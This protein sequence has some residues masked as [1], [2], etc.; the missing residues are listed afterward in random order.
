MNKIERVYDLNKLFM[1]GRIVVLY[2][3]RRVGKTTLVRDYL[4]KVR[5]KWLFEVGIVCLF[6]S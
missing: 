3:P 6:K 4:E 5:V 1:S 2:G